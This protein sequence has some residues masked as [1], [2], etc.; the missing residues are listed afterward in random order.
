MTTTHQVGKAT[1]AYDL[2]WE[3]D[4]AIPSPRGEESGDIVGHNLDEVCGHRRCAEELD[5]MGLL[6]AE[7]LAPWMEQEGIVSK[8][9]HIFASHLRRT[10]QTVAP[11]ARLTG[12]EVQQY[13]KGASELNPEG[14]GASVCPTVEAIK[15]SKGGST[16]VVAAHTAT[17]YRIM[18]EGNGDE[19]EGLGLD[20][21]DKTN[22][23]KDGRGAVPR[24]QYGN[25]WKVSIDANGHA[26]F[27]ER[28]I[29]EFSLNTVTDKYS[30]SNSADEQQEKQFDIRE[31]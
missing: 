20:T 13:P 22:F 30:N 7:L 12:L 27:E 23:P 25:V 3:G 26:T 29:V 24:E 18:G 28:Q 11:L 17:I 21:S 2:S 14:G 4:E 1:R 15:N 16:I 5:R 10:A 31:A 19:C 6:R 8:L 9:T